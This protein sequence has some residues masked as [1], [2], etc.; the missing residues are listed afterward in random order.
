MGREEPRPNLRFNLGG[1][2]TLTRLQEYLCQFPLLASAP[3]P[4]SSLVVQDPQAPP[5]LQ[6]FDPA[7]L[8]LVHHLLSLHMVGFFSSFAPLLLSPLVI[9]SR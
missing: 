8:C 5:C 4:P 7:L 2:F 1:N 3:H 9:S 6:A